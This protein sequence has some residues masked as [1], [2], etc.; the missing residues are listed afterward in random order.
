[1]AKTP[2]AIV[3]DHF[4]DRAVKEEAWPHE[5]NHK[6]RGVAVGWPDDKFYPDDTEGRPIIVE[7]KAS[8]KKKLTPK[9]E[10]RVVA[11]RDRH[12]LIAVVASKEAGDALIDI[13]SRWGGPPITNITIPAVKLES[14][15]NLA[16]A[17]LGHVDLQTWYVRDAKLISPL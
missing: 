6:G 13:V 10:E 12:Y 2:E 15:I 11:L 9:Q 5:R 17:N 7:F 8:P 14:A 3:R 4:I 1:M 16:L